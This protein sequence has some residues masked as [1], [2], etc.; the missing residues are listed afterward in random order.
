MTLRGF[1]SFAST[2]TMNLEPGITCVVGPNGSGKSNV[3][4]A[5]A[6]VMGE[7]GAKNLRGGQMADVIFAGTSGRAP[8]GRAQVSLTIDNTDGALPIDYSEVTIS[9]TLFRGGGSEY[10]INGTQVRLL[11]IQELLSDTGMGRQMHVIV[12]QGQLDAILGAGPEE[13]R[14]FIEEAA[15]VLK[16]RKRKER[17]LR[18]LDSM[19]ANLV[20]VRDLTNEIQRQL[21]PLA[22]QAETAR[23]AAVI[24]AD[25]RDA[26]A[27]ILADDVQN[28]KERLEAGKAS[29][30]AAEARKDALNKALQAAQ[31]RLADA[32][33]LARK[34]TPRTQH[35]TRLWQELS[36]V[37]A[38]LMTLSSVSAER[39]RSASHPVA[40]P[41]VDIVQLDERSQQAGEEDA[42]LLREV[43]ES[44]AR[45]AQA[46]KAREDAE[47]RARKAGEK[48]RHLE[49]E[50]SNRREHIARLIGD[51]NAAEQSLQSALSE[52]ERMREAVS[53]AEQRT[54]NARAEME[55]MAE[56]SPDD[57]AAKAHEQATKTRD[58]ARDLVDQLLNEER[59]AEAAR[60]TWTSRRDTLAQSLEPADA[61]AELLNGEHP[62]VKGSLAQFVSAQSGWENA[63]TALLEP[64][65]DAAVVTSLE[66]ASK[67]FSDTGQRRM[68]TASSGAAKDVEITGFT[69]ALDVVEF[70]TEVESIMRALLAGAVVCETASDALDALKNPLVTQA[71]TRQGDILTPVSARTSGGEHSSVLARHADYEHARKKADEADAHLRAVSEKLAK[72]RKAY[73]EALVAANRQLV[74]LRQADS[75]RAKRMEVRARA[76][77]KLRSA[78][79]EEQRLR[80]ALQKV[81]DGIERARTRLDEARAK[82]AGAEA[83]PAVENPAQ[84]REEADK[85]EE[86]AREARA[87]ETQ[88]RLDIRTLEEQSHRARDRA[89]SL[90]QQLARARADLEEYERKEAARK[91][92]LTRLTDAHARVEI[93]I[94]VAETALEQAASEL[95][96]AESER[97]EASEAAAAARREVDDLRAQLLEITDAVHRDVIA[98]QEVQ[99]RFEHVTTTA[100]NELG[101]EVPELLEKYGPHNLVEADD[102]YP[103]VR[104]E[105]EKRLAKAER[106]LDRLGKI[107][108][109]ALEEHDALSKR[110][111]FLADQLRDLVESKNDLLNIVDEVDERVEEVF[112]QAF[113]D[114]QEA[115]N[116][117]FAT[118]FPGGSGKLVL[119][120]PEKMLETGVEIEARPAGKKITR[121]S[122]LSGGERSLA[123]LAL[124]VA[125][126]KARPSPF[127]VLD[128]VEAALD[129]VN[130]SRLLT[131]FKE[132]Q[133][134]SQLII[135]THQK[136]TMKIADA[137]YGV[138]MRGGVTQVISSK[139]SDT[140]QARMEDKDA[141][142]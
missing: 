26:R 5:L 31:G 67:L 39:I 12:G 118:L 15:G 59:E 98:L 75:E 44:G 137:L 66:A 53:Q 78:E 24:Q 2:T 64:F 93:P 122:L 138:T 38:S 23:K 136:R 47:A 81:E 37:H 103:Y 124:L 132:L 52:V 61:T 3:V 41:R 121:L 42:K 74:A 112:T 11:D 134:D 94:H 48:V 43:E 84:A 65:A 108:P 117:V 141:V 4:D 32:E 20:R 55:G 6:W 92:E 16:H 119:T 135:I 76:T 105:Q 71:V 120:D 14:G 51:V 8:L 36:S 28:L 18:K 133:Q 60:A 70:S 107:N 69:S 58:D 109:L 33:E 111:Q 1:K 35:L 100:F 97:T 25:V 115:F 140:K 131:I 90:R 72:A 27:R 126:F 91:R 95:R 83:L 125:I 34:G 7:Q 99:L 10:S 104:A 13:R 73:D 45:L 129:D 86:S 62:E 116:H 29:G 56:E 30:S 87:L 123:A 19:E 77:S 88:T 127:Y 139:L 101:L 113:L 102:P 114:T 68:V 57:E 17:A 79:G 40:A 63:V 85:L 80:S 82:Q 89:R 128:E 96:E 142:S 22:R 130:L 54:L 49:A 106:A 50:H 110:H 46:V 21:R 9:R